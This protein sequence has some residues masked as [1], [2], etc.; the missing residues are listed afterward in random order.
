[1]DE[2]VW[3][4]LMVVYTKA[5]LPFSLLIRTLVWFV[6]KQCA[7]YQGL[8]NDQTKTTRAIIF[9]FTVDWYLVT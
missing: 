5:I 9:S 6:Q 8:H 1:M 3:Q 2:C 7:Q 4:S